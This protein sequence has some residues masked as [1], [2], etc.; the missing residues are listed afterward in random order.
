[1]PDSGNVNLFV[2]AQK[3]TIT[4]AIKLTMLPSRDGLDRQ[5]N[6]ATKSP[7]SLVIKFSKKSKKGRAPVTV[8]WSFHFLRGN[9]EKE[10]TA[11]VAGVALMGTAATAQTELE[12]TSA[13][14]K[15]LPILGVRSQS[16]WNRLGFRIREYL[17]HQLGYIRRRLCG[18]ASVAF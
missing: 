1:M 4:P 10:T 18:V 17:P 13:F 15:D 3:R 6:M 2:K 16:I 8:N 5:I 7:L 14:G 12:M 11:A 9:N